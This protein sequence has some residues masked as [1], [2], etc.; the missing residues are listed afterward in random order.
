[1]D[2]VALGGEGC[3]VNDFRHRR[4]GVNGRVDVLSSELLIQCQAHFGNEFGGIIANDVS[5]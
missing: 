3:F 4:V 5:A 1:M 2:R